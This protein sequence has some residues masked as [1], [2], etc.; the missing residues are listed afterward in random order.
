MA[1]SKASQCWLIYTFFALLLTLSLFTISGER[2]VF[3]LWR[4]G[5]EKKRLEE[6]TFLLQKENELLRERIYRLRHDDRYLEKI[7]R[8]DLGL[9]RA[10]EI[11]YRFPSSKARKDR[12][13]T[14]TESPSELHQSSEQTRLP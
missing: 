2:G 14:L 6:R 12:V 9:V 8:E 11:V 3:H 13:K 7:A 5:E 4:L 10:G 1:R